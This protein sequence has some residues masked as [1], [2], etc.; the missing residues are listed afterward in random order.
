MKNFLLAW[1]FLLISSTCFAQ[2]M[3][4]YSNTKWG[5]SPSDVINIEDGRAHALPKAENYKNMFGK[6]S[7]DRVNIGSGDYRVTFLFD[8]RDRLVQ[9]N[10]SSFEQKNAGI[11][12]D[13][14]R[15]LN[16][17]LTQKYGQP[18]YSE[19]D[20]KS[21]WNLDGTSIELM[22]M[23]SPGVMTQ[24]VIRYI[25]SDRTRADTSNI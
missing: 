16:S 10:V 24:V 21:V 1:V 15:M 6:V 9:T 2:Q 25:P 17:L 23:Y 11:N 7:I 18:V 19:K 8:K 22:H 12:Q 4:G 5:M 3:L 13:N 14:F 20:T